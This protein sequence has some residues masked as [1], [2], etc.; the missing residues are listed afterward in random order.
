MNPSTGT[1]TGMDSYAGNISD[2][3][4]LHKYL[5]AN[6]NPI[7]YVDPSGNAPTV[8]EQLTAI[9]ISSELDAQKLIIL[10]GVFN[11]I[12]KSTVTFLKG[13]DAVEVTL[14]FFQGLSFGGLFIAANILVACL[15]GVLLID[16]FIA[17]GIGYGYKDI[18]NAIECF[19]NG[20]PEDAWWYLLSAA[21]NFTLAGCLGYLKVRTLKLSEVEKSVDENIINSDNEKSIYIPK[22]GKGNPIPLRKQRING[23]DIPL[24]DSAAEGRPHTVLGGKVSSETGE[25]YRQSATFMG[26]SWPTANG[27]EVPISEVHW[28]V[29]GRP[30]EH[31]NP[32]QHVFIFDFVNYYWYRGN[33][34]YY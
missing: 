2:P 13:V 10:G 12:V 24:P 14:A 20:H 18:Y 1:F 27:Y 15:F 30:A 33:P 19:Q 29:H 3:D 5:Y 22:D 11:A 23:Q 34:E 28:T 16:I 26:G 6:G 17:E 8:Q 25:V 4:T 31:T 32:H 7:K 9:G 21:G